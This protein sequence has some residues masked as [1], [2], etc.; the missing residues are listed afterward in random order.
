VI[1]LSWKWPRFCDTDFWEIDGVL[2][3][4]SFG[5]LK[6]SVKFFSSTQYLDSYLMDSITEVD[7]VE[8]G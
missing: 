6:G 5:I 2:L 4:F 8:Q 3:W 1:A 7:T